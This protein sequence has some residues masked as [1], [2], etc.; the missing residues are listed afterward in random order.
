MQT[1]AEMLANAQQNKYPGSFFFAK[2]VDGRNDGASLFAIIAYQTAIYLPGMRQLIEEAMLHDP[3]LVTKSMDVQLESLILDPLRK[4]TADFVQ[5]TPTVLIDGLDECHDSETQRRIL[6]LIANVVNT[7]NAP[8]RFLI[9]SRPEYWIRDSFVQPLVSV[10]TK[11][12]CLNDPTE[13]A[14][15]DEDIETYFLDEYDKI[16]VKKSRFMKNIA[17]PWPSNDI[18]GRLARD[19]SGLFAYASTVIRFV[20]HSSDYFDP[21]KQL[22]LITSPGPQRATAFTELDKLCTRI[23]S[24]FPKPEVLKVVLAGLMLK[25]DPACI[26]F[27]LGVDLSKMHMALNPLNSV[28]DLD[29]PIQV[30]EDAMEG[31]FNTQETFSVPAYHLSF[32]EFLVDRNRSGQFLIDLDATA[33]HIGNIFAQAI[34]DSLDG[35]PRFRNH[36]SVLYLLFNASC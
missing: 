7:P 6:T 36:Q 3:S 9:A 5:H 22:S 1:I 2:D 35:K 34:V 11:R 20:G 14:S 25:L 21:V 32:R 10:R 23:L 31:V 17:R 13:Y 12:L 27:Y 26:E 18:I 19:A 4:Y 29:K 28:V 8:L 15:A 30:T 24:V 33:E 16:Y